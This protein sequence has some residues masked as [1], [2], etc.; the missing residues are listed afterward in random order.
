VPVF[1]VPGKPAEPGLF[2]AGLAS[3]ADGLTASFVFVV[4]GDVADAG[5]QP[6]PV[7]VGRVMASS[8]RRVAGSRMA[9]RCGYSALR[10]P[11]RLSIQA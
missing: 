4:G 1:A 3:L 10:C 2:Q 11:L 9:S 7:V 6:D 5:V 8:A